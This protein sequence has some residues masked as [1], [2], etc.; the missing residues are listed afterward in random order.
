MDL[1]WTWKPDT[2]DADRW[3]NRA[4]SFGPVWRLAMGGPGVVSRCRGRFLYDLNGDGDVDLHD[5][6]GLTTNWPVQGGR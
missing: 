1:A 4:A 2:T 5:F 6:A 3:W